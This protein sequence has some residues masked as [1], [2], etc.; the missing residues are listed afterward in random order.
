MVKYQHRS[1]CR[2]GKLEKFFQRHSP[3]M[4]LFLQGD[5]END[6][7]ETIW[8]GHIVTNMLNDEFHKQPL[9]EAD[10]RIKFDV[11]S[12][13]CGYIGLTIQCYEQ[14]TGIVE[15]DLVYR[16]YCGQLPQVQSH[17]QLVHGKIVMTQ[18]S[19]TKDK[20]TF[21]RHKSQ[22]VS[23]DENIIEWKLNGGKYFYN[24]LYEEVVI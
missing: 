24:K 9:W 13:N 20:R 5:P 1:L 11:I 19:G 16:L 7:G 17:A 15:S 14:S 18:V 22:L 8:L 3:R 4:I 2:G 12:L 21:S 6:F 10:K 23:E